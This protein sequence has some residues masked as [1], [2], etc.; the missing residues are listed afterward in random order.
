LVFVR[1]PLPFL[2]V[3]WRRF[4][5]RNNWPHFRVFRIQRQPFLKP[6]LG[7]GLDRVDWAFGLAHPAIDAFVWVDDEHVLALVEAVHGT[8]FDA[9]HEF[10]ANAALVDDV[11]QLRVLSA[12]RRAEFIHGALALVA[13][14]LKMNAEKTTVLRLDRHTE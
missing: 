3:G 1:L 7:V 2:I 6:R 5:H 14:W 4:F 9:V 12:D 11:G 13:L 8:H 10:A